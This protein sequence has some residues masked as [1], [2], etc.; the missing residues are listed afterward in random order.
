LAATL[1]GF[2]TGLAAAFGAGLAAAM[3]TGFGEAF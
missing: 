1:V 2:A 3:L